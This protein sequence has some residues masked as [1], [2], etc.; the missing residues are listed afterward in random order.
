MISP[1]KIFG[2]GY[3]K[4]KKIINLIDWTKNV[5]CESFCGG[6]NIGLN[7]PDCNENG[8]PIRKFVFDLNPEVI[9]TWKMIQEE[10]VSLQNLLSGTPY[11]ESNFNW[12]KS[13]M[14]RYSVE[15]LEDEWMRL[16]FVQAFLV[17]NRMSR[18]A[19]N[20]T[21]GWSDRLRRGMPEYISAWKTFIDD[22]PAVS[23][24]IQNVTFD[25]GDAIDCINR[26]KLDRDDIIFYHDPPFVHESR[27]CKTGYGD[28]ELPTYDHT[29]K[30]GNGRLTHEKFLHTIL[31]TRGTHYI[32]GYHNALYDN[33]IG[34]KVLAEWNVKNSASQLK[35]KT[36]RVEVLWKIS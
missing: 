15:D 22:L 7:S 27:T 31:Q 11:N 12:A 1:I 14:K 2:G 19:D 29:G 17:R 5:Y 24:K 10:S 13:Y 20:K 28:Y 36:D 26:H 6:F 25:C 34:D 16:C 32:S 9:T 4:S 3:Y 18:G 8:E 30:S 21:F 33:L 35:K 23:R